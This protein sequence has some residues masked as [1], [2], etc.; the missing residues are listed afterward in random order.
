MKMRIRRLSSAIISVVAVLLAACAH[1]S[2]QDSVSRDNVRVLLETDLGNIVVEVFPK[3]APLSANDFLAY[4]DAGLY[5]GGAF[6]RVVRLDNDHGDPKI[7]VVQ[8]GLLDKSNAR[9][10]IAHETTKMTGLRHVDGTLSLA[11]STVGT[12]G[13]AAFFIVLG[14]QPGLDH[15]ARRN[16]DGQGFA[17]FGRVVSGMEIVRRINRMPADAA[18]ENAYLKG[19]MLTQPVLIKKASRVD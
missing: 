11:R 16:P 10:P 2:M 4:V 6:Y 5:E 18:T 15:G 19:Q 7:E 17:A 3:V 8:G 1:D 14:E 12:G 9:P 13:A